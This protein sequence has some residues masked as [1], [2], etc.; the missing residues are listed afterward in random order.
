MANYIVSD[1]NLTAVADAIRTK[2][3]T[4][5]ALEFPQG[6]VDAIDDIETGG[7]GGGDEPVPEDGKTR[8]WIH[9]AEDTP[10]NR[11][12]F[13]VRFKSSVTNNVT[14]DWGDGTTETRGSTT[15][16]NYPHTYAKGGDYVIALT[17]N[18]G[19]IEFYCNSNSY[20]IW[21]SN[22]SNSNTHHRSSIRKIV[23]G[24]NIS[25]SYMLQYAFYHCYKLTNVMIPNVMSGIGESAFRECFSLTSITLPTALTIIKDYA[26]AQCR[27]LTS[28][29]IPNNCTSIGPQVF[30]GCSALTS[31]TLPDNITT[32]DNSVFSG[33]G[34]LEK[35]T[36]PNSVTSIGEYTFSDCLTLTKIIIPK[37]VATIK[38]YAFRLCSSISEYHLEP[39]TPPSLE[40]TNAFQGISS[41]CIIYVP[42]SADHSILNAYKT[43]TNWSTYASYMQEE[44]Q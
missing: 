27:S 4:S 42:Y 2:G 8:L 23:F 26:F 7:G 18:S 32:L 11:L 43:A 34:S 15:A 33:C 35:I 31:I 44:P 28:I 24:S 9:I 36:I 10:A 20:A 6:F 19:T 13:Y 1:T 22:G 41:D 17:V 21:G 37:N 16:N 29:I 38:K 40:N 39:I 14:I 12:T 5:A 30:S 25:T 3:G